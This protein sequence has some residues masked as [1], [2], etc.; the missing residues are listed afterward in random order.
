MNDEAIEACEENMSDT[1]LYDLIILGSGAAGYAAGIYAGRARLKTLVLD[2]MGGG[3]QMAITDIVE[4][5]PGLTQ[6]VSGQE[7]AE[8]MRKQMETFGTSVTFDQVEKVA[9]SDDGVTLKGAYGKYCGRTLLISTGAK[10]RE[11]C[12]PGEETLK[13]RGV[14]YCA[15]CDGAFFKD[16]HVAVVGGGD[17]AVKEALYL[18]RIAKKVTVIHRRDKLRAEMVMQEKALA[19]ANIEF[20]WFH[21]VEEILGQG[22]V[23]GVR[24]RNVQTDETSELAL[25]GVFVFIGIEPNT[26]LFRGHLKLD[27]SGFVATDIDMRTSHPRVWAAGDVRARSVRQIATAVGD[28]VTAMLH[29]QEFLDTDTPPRDLPRSC[30]LV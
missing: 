10:H 3:G 23:K 9:F 27:P 29:I 16:Q 7:L 18:A 8:T 21:V 12:V 20:K 19:A 11:L 30:S 24:V 17:T 14:S 22:K 1:P 13:G 6:A 5:Y 25:D 26:D 4:N 2:G 28:G 15:T